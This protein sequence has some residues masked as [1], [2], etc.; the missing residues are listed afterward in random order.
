MTK[1]NKFLYHLAIFLG[2]RS[3]V[4]T[5]K[6]GKALLSEK[7]DS[8]QQDDV[9]PQHL[10]YLRGEPEDEAQWD[11]PE[12]VRDH[13]NL[14]EEVKYC[15]WGA[16]AGHAEAQVK[17]ARMYYTGDG[18]PASDEEATKWWRKAADQGHAGAQYELGRAYH[19]RIG[20]PQK[21]E[22]YAEAFKWWRKAGDQ[23]LAEAQFALGVMYAYGDGMPKDNAEAVKW[24]RRAAEQGYPQAQVKLGVM[25]EYGRG[26]PEDDTEAVQWYRK[27]AEQGDARAQ[28]AFDRMQGS[29]GC[30]S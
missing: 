20:V 15:L 5:D 28:K 6:L 27:A 22:D 1:V 26:V 4:N 21:Q 25:Y 12:Y 9:R 8:P 10:L 19:D 14:S 30:L 13:L 7:K 2:L 29:L 24:C 23:G 18:V 17:I 16:H 11:D 3:A